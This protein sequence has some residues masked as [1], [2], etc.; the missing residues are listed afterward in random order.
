MTAHL[1][2]K[3]LARSL[4]GKLVFWDRNPT[5]NCVMIWIRY[6]F[7]NYNYI[8]NYK[9]VL[10]VSCSCAIVSVTF[11]LFRHDCFAVLAVDS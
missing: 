11:A 3:P 4:T 8:D 6:D 7:L 10:T 9:Q 2:G 1:S 5:N